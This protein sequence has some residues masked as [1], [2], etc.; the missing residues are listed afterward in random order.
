M[1]IA[2]VSLCPPL[3][4]IPTVN[5]FGSSHMHARMHMYSHKTHHYI[6]EL[7]TRHTI[8]YMNCKHGSYM[9][10]HVC[11]LV[12]T[13][14]AARYQLQAGRKHLL[15][16]RNHTAVPALNLL[17]C[18]YRRLQPRA[19]ARTAGACIRRRLAACFRQQCSR[20]ARLQVQETTCSLNLIN[21]ACTRPTERWSS[22]KVARTLVGL[23]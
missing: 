19:R 11:P 12:N 21:Y 7:Q 15:R 4:T 2:N 10:M 23:Y 6:C 18:S 20:L 13:H 17:R 5:G 22:E 14:A 8:I 1:W 16:M 3:C 9:H